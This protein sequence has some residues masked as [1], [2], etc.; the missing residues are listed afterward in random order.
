M[1]RSECCD[2]MSSHLDWA[3]HMHAD[4]F[5]CADALVLFRPEYQ[6]YGIIIHDGGSS[7]VVMSFCPWCGT[8]LPESQRD[9]WFDE[10]RARGIDPHSGDPIPAE[11]QDDRWLR[12]GA[13]E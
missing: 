6:E 5:D 3:C 2:Y 12:A 10:L 8:K 7:T 4:R 13:G 1:P 9:R 11:F